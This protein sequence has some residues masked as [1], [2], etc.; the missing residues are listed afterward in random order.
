MSMAREL[1]LSSNQ[2]PWF[3]DILRKQL[4]RYRNSL[5]LEWSD[6]GNLVYWYQSTDVNI[7]D[8]FGLICKLTAYGAARSD[9]NATTSH[10]GDLTMLFSL[11][12][13]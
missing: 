4:C 2:S 1:C 7:I 6:S 3:I 5:D 9:A 11:H 10:G 8:V 12:L 13:R